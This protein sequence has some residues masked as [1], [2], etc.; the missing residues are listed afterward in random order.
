MI[1]TT[2]KKDKTKA[3]LLSEQVKSILLNR[4]YLKAFNWADYNY[5]KEV[6]K[7]SFNK[8][9]AIAERF[10]DDDIQSDFEDYVF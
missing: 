7:D 5:F 4:G 2:I 10:M 8:A 3:Y 6:C 9:L 1:S